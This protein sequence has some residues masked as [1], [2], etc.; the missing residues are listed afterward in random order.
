VTLQLKKIAAPTPVKKKAAPTPVKKK[1]APFQSIAPIKSADYPLIGTLA[2]N[3]I[4][5]QKGSVHDPFVKYWDPTTTE[6]KRKAYSEQIE[7]MKKYFSPMIPNNSKAHIYILGSDKEWACEVFKKAPDSLMFSTMY[8]VSSK[9]ETTPGGGLILDAKPPADYTDYEGAGNG[10]SVLGNAVGMVAMSNCDTKYFNESLLI[11]ETF[12]AIQWIYT[13]HKLDSKIVT[14]ALKIPSHKGTS[15]MW[16]MEGSAQ[17]M[18]YLLSA[19]GIWTSAGEDKRG[20]ILANTGLWKKSY[21]EFAAD[22]LYEAYSIGAVMYEYMLAKYGLERTL[23]YWPEAIN[24][25]KPNDIQNSLARRAA[26][27]VAFQ[28]VFGLSFENFFKEV[29]PYIEWSLEKADRVTSSLKSNS[30]NSSGGATST[31]T[32]PT[33]KK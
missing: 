25:L 26:S 17:Y 21:E 18:G 13:S 2:K 14:E 28:R 12:H 3:T 16:M 31:P 27:K 22:Y 5:N 33:S 9:C 24:S 20:F 23:I 11:H 1:T 6:L 8:K 4:L 30:D 10:F 15:P 32:P 29:K 19:D 7:I